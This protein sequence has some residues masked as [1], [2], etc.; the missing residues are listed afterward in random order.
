MKQ[1]IK[2]PSVGESVT[3]ATIGEWQKKNGD[4]VKQ[5][6]VLVVMET[7]KA[8]MDLVA[9]Q[10][11][12][13][14]I[15]KQEGEDVKVGEVIAELDTSISPPALEKEQP[16][17]TQKALSNSNSHTTFDSPSQ[18]QEK[19]ALP[20]DKTLIDNFLKKDKPNTST[21][22][23]SLHSMNQ[24]LSP[25]VRKLITENKLNPDHITGQGPGGRITKGDVLSFIQN[26]ASKTTS[27]PS[28][29][30]PSNIPDRSGIGTLRTPF[31]PHK[32]TEATT[33]KQ[34]QY[35]T[36]RKKMSTIR[37][38]IAERLVKSQQ[39]T[40]TLTTFNEID[41]SKVINLRAQYKE[42]FQ[43]RH[44][45]K[46]GFMGFFIKA[47]IHAL[48][49]FPRVNAF[50]EGDEMVYNHSCHIGVAVST[51]RGLVVPVIHEADHKGMAELEKA[52]LF[53]AEKA[54]DG[55]ISPD[56]LMGGTFTISNGGVFGSLMSTPILNPPQ[57]GI[58]G[59]HKIEER[60][61]VVD[62]QIQIKP[63]MYIALSYDHRL[64][65]G[66]E[67]V[68]FLLKIK[69]CVEDPIRLIMDV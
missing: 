30:P 5:N 68:G 50:I 3:E 67:S 32:N 24:N 33:F 6:E 14:N 29:K 57:S 64:V 51:D 52:V 63:M 59:M 31:L 38:R 61:V 41:M 17:Q 15:F 49:A 27:S 10:S 8:S 11:G 9:E 26:R 55:K 54:R 7:D 62:G 35:K 44:Q 45:V 69:E 4:Y 47:T 20:S 37:K 36:T 22:K 13:L 40:A 19:Q 58:L 12:Q 25:S 23:S 60:P 21:Q 39:S 18:N 53:Y 46:L 34:A 42:A 16:T 2:V 65:D 1:Q 28:E 56:D 48:Q 66:K 43:K